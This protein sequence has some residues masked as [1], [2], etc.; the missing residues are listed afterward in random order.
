MCKVPRY[1]SYQQ[2][3]GFVLQ[4]LGLK[5]WGLVDLDDDDDDA[6]SVSLPEKKNWFLINKLTK[7]R[8][9]KQALYKLTGCIS[10]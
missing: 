2:T 9:E 10:T 5:I 4:S 8:K 1:R 3:C 6:V 7:K